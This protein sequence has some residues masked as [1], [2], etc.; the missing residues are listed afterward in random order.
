MSQPA[1]QEIQALYRNYQR[2]V[3]EWPA[4]KIRPNKD[5]KPFLA[6]R[7]ED[8]FRKPLQD[9]ADDTF[10]LDEVKKQY[11][12]LE[13]LLAS[14]FKQKYPLSD[15]ILTPAGNPSYYTSLLSSLGTTTKDGKKTGLARFFGK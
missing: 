15:N 4:D 13:R 2:L 8:T 7:M 14:E 9:H 5:I 3:Q 12:A 1:R 6:T 10:D 11:N